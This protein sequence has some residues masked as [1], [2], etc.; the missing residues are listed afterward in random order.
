[1]AGIVRLGD[2][3][4]GHDCYPPRT[5]ITMSGDIF[6]NNRPVHRFGD[7][8]QNHDCPDHEPHGGIY[9]GYHSVFGNGSAVQVQGD[10]ISCGS[11]CAEGSSDCFVS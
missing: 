2:R 3:C 9:I 10:P 5:G 1:M 6:C 11:F 8:L 7:I 4:T